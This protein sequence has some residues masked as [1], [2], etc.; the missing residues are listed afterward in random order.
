MATAESLREPQTSAEPSAPLRLL[1]VDDDRALRSSLERVLAQNGYA[2][3]AAENAQQARAQLE[4]AS[5]AVVLLDLVLPDAEGLELLREIKA[6]Q[7]ETEVLVVTAYGSIESAVEAMRWGAYD[8]LTKPFHTAEL[9]T[10]LGKALEKMAL[11]RE[12][13]SLR[14]QLS[15]QTISRILVGSRAP[16]IGR[17]SC[18]GRG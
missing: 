9:L 4:A 17:A 12:N 5:F 1:V 11:Q 15:Q 16:K 14:Y 7:P 6:T 13:S 18:R 8:Y 10:T 2:V 3:V